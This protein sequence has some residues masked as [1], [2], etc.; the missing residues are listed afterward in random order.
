MGDL[1]RELQGRPANKRLL[2][3]VFSGDPEAGGSS[4]SAVWEQDGGIVAR[5]DRLVDPYM[6]VLSDEVCT[7]LLALNGDW[8]HFAI[9]CTSWS[10][11]KT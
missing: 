5:V 8:Y 6:N 7:Q 10:V 2:V 4:L 11:A 3:E 1:P 9:P